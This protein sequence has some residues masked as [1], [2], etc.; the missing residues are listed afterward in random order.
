MEKRIILASGFQDSLDQRG[1]PQNPVEDAGDLI[2]GCWTCLSSSLQR[3]CRHRTQNP[4]FPQQCPS[5]SLNYPPGTERHRYPRLHRG[6]NVVCSPGSLQGE[7]LVI[8]V[9]AAAAAARGNP[10]SATLMV[11]LHIYK[12][13]FLSTLQTSDSEATA[14]GF[15]GLTR[16]IA[17]WHQD[18]F[19]WMRHH[20]FEDELK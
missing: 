15:T 9:R 2:T 11:S 18:R 3:C 19:A 17:F 10:P 7:D 12:R 14:A 20:S 13:A 1:L 6:D 5:F 4:H 16:R 8:F